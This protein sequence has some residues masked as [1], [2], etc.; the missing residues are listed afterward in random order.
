MRYFPPL[1]NWR[2]P[3]L[4]KPCLPNAGCELSLPSPDPRQVMFL[5]HFDTAMAEQRRYLVDGNSR[6]QQF[7]GEGVAEHVR[8]ATFGCAIGI[9]DIGYTKELKKAA[10]VPLDSA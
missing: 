2:L 5:G 7:H 3:D 8:M 9:S 10:L 1:R 6:Q 4:R